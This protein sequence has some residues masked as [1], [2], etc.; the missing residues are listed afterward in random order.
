MINAIVYV[1]ALII[2][3][4]MSFSDLKKKRVDIRILLFSGPLLVFLLIGGNG[5]DYFNSL[6]AVSLFIGVVCIITSILSKEAIGRGDSYVILWCGFVFGFSIFIKMMC[7][8]LLLGFV[9][10]CIMTAVGKK[11]PIP[12]VPLMTAGLIAALL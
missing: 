12:F 9:I 1:L 6:R 3:I 7:I 11:R 8:S 2:M 5:A 4:L 10:A